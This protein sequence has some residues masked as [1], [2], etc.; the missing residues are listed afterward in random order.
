MSWLAVEL[1]PWLL[2][3]MG[4]GATLTV[5][6]TTRRV[7]VERWV[8]AEEAPREPASVEELIAAATTAPAAT[9]ATG[10]AAVVGVVDGSP[11]PAYRGDAG[12]P[13]PWE[14]D[15]QWSQPVQRSVTHAVL[16]TDDDGWEDPADNWRNWAVPGP[17]A[18]A[19]A[20]PG[21]SAGTGARL[22]D[23][24]LFAAERDATPFDP[25]EAED[26][27]DGDF[28]PYAEPVEAG[29]G[30]DDFEHDQPIDLGPANRHAARA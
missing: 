10:A 23:A 17:A 7:K 1:W 14:A 9:E 27:S 16:D 21:A 20:A 8:P 29:G 30:A 15:E 2:L 22:S 24:E 6:G 5:L 28:Y 18:A 11:F 13:R 25:D 12:N 26:D 4:L 19:G 3:S